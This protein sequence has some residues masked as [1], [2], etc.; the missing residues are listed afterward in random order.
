VPTL[1]DL[2]LPPEQ[3]PATFKVGAR[4]FDPNKVGFRSDGYD[5]FEFRTT[6]R[7]NKNG[8]HL[9]GTQL[10]EADRR[11]LLESLKCVEAEVDPRHPIRGRSGILAI[12]QRL[13]RDNCWARQQPPN[14]DRRSGHNGPFRPATPPCNQGK[15]KARRSRD[16]PLI[17][18]AFFG[19]GRWI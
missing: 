1:Y 7:G 10:S 6:Q 17:C 19:C 18:R 13:A 16:N 2:L 15:G 12:R 11:D 3:R 4:E 9:Y 5:G 8:G 14:D